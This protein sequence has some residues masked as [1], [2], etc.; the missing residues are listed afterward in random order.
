MILAVKNEQLIS[1][2]RAL[3]SKLDGSIGLLK[4]LHSAECMRD[5][6]TTVREVLAEKRPAS[7][8]Q[9]IASHVASHVLPYV[10]MSTTSMTGQE[11][12]DG[13]AWNAFGSICTLFLPE[14][15]SRIRAECI[16]HLAICAVTFEDAI[17]NPHLFHFNE[18]ADEYLSDNG[19][20]FDHRNEIALTLQARV[21][22]LLRSSG[23]EVI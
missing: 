2:V 7:E 11:F 10:G 22:T 21:I 8:I 3:A 5:M 16:Q 12:W 14:V 17:A 6:S 13:A 9:T 23:A 15:T 4:N 1:V 20:E 19:A 18:R